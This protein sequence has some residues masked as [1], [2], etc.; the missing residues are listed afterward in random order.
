MRLLSLGCY[1]SSNVR[2]GFPHSS[3]IVVIDYFSHFCQKYAKHILDTTFCPPPFAKVGDFKTHLS[4]CPS[5]RHKN[6]NLALI[7]WGINDRALIFCMHDPC[8][9]PFLLAPCRDLG[10]LQGRSCAWQGTTILR[11]S[12]SR[13]FGIDVAYFGLVT[14]RGGGVDNISPD[15]TQEWEITFAETASL[16]FIWHVW[17]WVSWGC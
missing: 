13:L 17:N 3:L 16:G 12:L 1:K 11:I 15:I 7:F 10:L 4:V 5:A 8:D 9:K 14:V 2:M 6:S